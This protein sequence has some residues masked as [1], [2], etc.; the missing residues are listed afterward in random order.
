MKNE[1]EEK[2]E[3]THEPVK[4]YPAALYAAVAIASAYLAFAFIAGI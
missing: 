2:T 4:G 3:L 1:Q